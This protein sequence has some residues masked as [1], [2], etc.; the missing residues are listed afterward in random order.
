MKQHEAARAYALRGWMVFPI[1]PGGKIPATPNGFKDA[2][3]DLVEIDKWWGGRAGW[4]KRNVAIVT[5]RSSGIWTLDSDIDPET[6]EFTGEA[7]IERLQAIHGPLPPCPMQSTPKGGRHRLF[8]W[9]QDGG[10]LPRRIK[11]AS[12]LDALG[13]RIEGGEEL[14]GY[15]II[16][17]SERTDGKYEWIVHPDDCP[18]PQAP[19]WLVQMV[20][21]ARTERPEDLPRIAPV[22]G[23]STTPYGRKTLA[24]LCQDIATCVNSQDVNLIAKATR[25]GSVQAGGNIDYQE[26]FTSAVE[27]AMQ[28]KNMDPKYP[29]TRK[30]IEKKVAK[31]MAHGAKDPTYVAPRETRQQSEFSPPIPPPIGEKVER[32]KPQLIVSNPEKPKEEKVVEPPSWVHWKKN[33]WME[34]HEW[35][36]KDEET[37]KPTA[38]RNIQLMIEFHPELQGMFSY[39]RFSDQIIINRGLPDDKRAEYPRELTD[40]D[41]TAV[42]SWLSW[43]G[44]SPAIN[45][46]ASV[47]REVAFRYSFDPLVD[48][49]SGLKWDGVKR[50]DTWLTY[51]AGSIDTKYV[52]MVGRKFLIS[53]IARAM[54]PGCKVDTM[55]ILEGPQGIKKSTLVRVLCGPIWFSDQVGDVTNK[56]S[57]QA[58]QGIWVMEIPEMD[59]FT[60]AE[61]NAVKDFLA[62]LFDRYRPPYGR[63]MVRRERRCVFFG[64]INPDG[65][66]YLKDTTGNRRYW[67]VECTAAD[68][69]GISADRDQIWAEAMEAYKAGER[70]WVE[71]EEGA[72]VAPEQDAR[73]D[74]EVWEPK[75]RKWIKEKMI[76]IAP[77]GKFCF[78]TADVLTEG[79]GLEAKMQKQSEKI[80]ASKVLKM[81][82]CRDRNNANGIDGRS[83]EKEKE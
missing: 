77:G 31:A 73:R 22:I 18:P 65:V 39:N 71:G 34:A 56:D 20:R 37:L 49:L 23:A 27:A 41:E 38:L 80:R 66:G 54:S 43:H 51:Y 40:Y 72:V 28:M 46:V 12:G 30:L 26:A 74:D 68:I 9:P 36:W 57:S 83:W 44:L 14:A 75:I 3:R 76:Q 82:G 33:K 2:S 58:I 55:L 16:A 11:F 67:P 42:A 35:I 25:I 4:E 17:P 78:T 6:G 47:I 7:E 59:K 10:D 29:W 50:I 53:A 79:I 52:R 32:P 61:A 62:R 5:S 81:L 64:T 60:R 63:N 69:E 1:R 8:A 24:A 15:F 70:W 13:S 48:W 45:T 21:D 19:M